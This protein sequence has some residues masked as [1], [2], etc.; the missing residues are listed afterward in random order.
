MTANNGVSRKDASWTII[1]AAVAAIL[2]LIQ[3][4][5]AARYMS[6][7]SFGVLAIVNIVI[8]II[9]T[10]QEMGLSSYCV[11]LGEGVPKSHSTLFWI[12]SF[13]GLICALLVA[14]ASSAI[15]DFYGIPELRSLLPF[16]AINFIVIGVSTQYQANYIRVFL[17]RKL[18]LFELV[19]RSVGFTVSVSLLIS[20]FDG[21][22]SII[23]GVLAFGCVKFIL[24]IFFADHTWHPKFEFDLN[25][26]PHAFRYG[27][28]QAGAQ[29]I[30]Q[31]RQQ[32]DQIIVGKVLGT[33]VLGVY[34][35]A[36]E[37]IALP[38]RFLQP[39][40]SR[41]MLPTLARDQFDSEKLKVSFIK[42]LKYTAYVSAVV[43]SL[44]ALASSWGIELLYGQGYLSVAELIPLLATFAA[45]RPVGLSAG[46]LAQA[47]GKTSVELKWNIICVLA[48]LPIIFLPVLHPSVTSF[49]IAVSFSQL[50]LTFLTYP[51][52][53]RPIL[54]IPAENFYRILFFP[55]V[56]TVIASALSF[57]ITLPTLLDLGIN[58]QGI[59]RSIFELE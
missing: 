5:I 57:Y 32:A 52:F 29:I 38:M 24:M 20:G 14:I 12:S 45:L 26:A 44:V 35:L 56:L 51:L 50:V 28:N 3:L 7:Y 46:M 10:L 18:A 23:C 55:F 15:S 59:I 17:A 34:S 37:F 25:L 39:L 49:A 13:L 54:E 53:V 48:T 36:K 42:S 1:A 19:A 8:W 27:S 9:L 11:H 40:F 31:M 58:P 4:A 41:L 30:N 6:A 47:I 16:A 22:F 21:V 2:Q 43:Y 33:E